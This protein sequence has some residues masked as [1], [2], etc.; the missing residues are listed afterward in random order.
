MK[1]RT[2]QVMAAILGVLL[3]WPP[4]WSAATSPDTSTTLP[5][6]AI[7]SPIPAA[8]L[9]E[10]LPSRSQHKDLSHPVFTA[11]SG[12]HVGFVGEPKTDKTGAQIE[13]TT[14]AGA[15]AELM[16]NGQVVPFTQ[17]GEEISNKKSGEIH[18]IYVGVPLVAGPNTL[19][20][21]A[22]GAD[23]L[24]GPSVIETIFGAGRPS[25]LTSTIVGPL[26]ADGKTSAVVRIAAR[27]QWNRPT[28]A[29]TVVRV[30]IV[31]GDAHF[32]QLVRGSAAL[33]AAL[34]NQAANSDL[35]A[36]PNP[37]VEV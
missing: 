30:A 12:L 8:A 2:H 25:E 33:N 13:L 9:P 21:T 18:F 19:V 1:I 17:L 11:T 28:R 27:D 34:Q 22:L 23:G 37:A 36:T 4:N 32:E 7:G 16:V 35:S 20:A 10:G 26:I 6:P 3:T 29:G 24:R 31:D 5:A 14:G 15:G